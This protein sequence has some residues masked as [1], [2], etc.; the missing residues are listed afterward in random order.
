[1]EN[2]KK[3][4][5]HNLLIDYN[6]EL[7]HSGINGNR[8]AQRLYAISKIGST[9]DGGVTRIGYS[10][11]E[12]LAKE[13]VIEWM[14]EAGLLVTM[15]GAGNVFGKKQGLKKNN[16]VVSGSHLDSVPNGGN[17]DG[18]LG[19]ICA[20]EV[21]EA[22]N[23]VGYTPKDS[24][25][26]AIFSDEEG[27]R[28]QSGLTGSRAFMGEIDKEEVVQLKDTDGNKFNEVITV[29][30]SNL[31]KFIDSKSHK[32]N[33]KT[34]V[35]VHIE[36][37]KVLEKNNQP[38][39]IVT[40]IAGPTW[41]SI[42]FKGESGH[43]GNTPM[44]ERK[45]SLIAASI[46]I[47]NIEELPKKVSDS[48]VATVGKIDVFPNGINVISGKVE[49]IIDIRDIQAET[50]DRLVEL[51]KSKA[52]EIAENR[53]IKC[54]IHH[55]SNIQPI[56]IS[57]NIQKN[58][59]DILVEKNIKPIYIPSGAG[60]DAMIIGTKYPVAMLFVRSKEGISH[61]PKEWSSLNDCVL[62]VHVLKKYIES[63]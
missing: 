7:S 32:K 23:E 33:I 43:A 1:M 60:H 51:V 54:E 34:F 41:L 25:E 40:G 4:F 24:F 53:N 45:D 47:K 16:I 8:V 59:A 11:E 22:W 44:D 30:N 35:E 58:L 37:G 26:I 56:P 50:R 21:V 55:N 29:Y 17:F 48:A 63:L 10:N 15:D 36:Q 27:S 3:T 28:F 52:Y 5:L 6:N 12:K 18:P 49:M 46:L 9:D 57:S 13:L 2:K 38:V 42:K 62:G 14:K 61:N 19:V 31:K 20:L 39:G